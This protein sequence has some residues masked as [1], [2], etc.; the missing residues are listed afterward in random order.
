[1]S[2]NADVRLDFLG[3]I[4]AEHRQEL[5]N[6]FKRQYR[7]RYF[8]R[9]ETLLQCV[10]ALRYADPSRPTIREL[11]HR[12]H[13]HITDDAQMLKGSCAQR[14]PAYATFR[15]RIADMPREFVWKARAGREMGRPSI[16]AMVS[17]FE[18]ILPTN[19]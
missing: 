12:L 18:N 9:Q 14:L 16:V 3:Q 11:W 19:A 2:Q 7:G 10:V 4:D 6:W 15:S 1:M 17:R 5:Q 8:T 13:H